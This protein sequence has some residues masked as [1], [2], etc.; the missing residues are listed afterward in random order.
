MSRMTRK[1]P[2]PCLGW[3]NRLPEAGEI[4]QLAVREQDKLG[5]R[6]ELV[7]V[8]ATLDEELRRLAAQAETEA[9]REWSGE[10]IRRAKEMPLEET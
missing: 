7:A 8:I 3:L 1:H 4:R 2:S 6:A 10:E 9:A 5:R